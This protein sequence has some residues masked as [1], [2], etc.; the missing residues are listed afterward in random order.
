M[1][2]QLGRYQRESTLLRTAAVLN[3]ADTR[4]DLVVTAA[5]AQPS[6]K[7]SLLPSILDRLIEPK[8]NE[9]VDLTLRGQSVRELEEAVR[10]DLQDLLNTRQ[11][12]VEGYP[13]DTEL[14]HSLLT[15]GLPELSSFDPTIPDQRRS[16]QAI[17]ER[18][19]R[20]FE[21]RLMDVRVTSM[22]ADAASGR[23]LR[24]CVEALLRVSPAPLPITFDTV[25]KPGSGEWQVVEQ[26]GR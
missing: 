2:L 15:F 4:I 18:T 17:I 1:R 13:D 25:V 3:S 21:P 14:S 11:T 5:M 26:G 20:Q 10:R 6:A 12:A 16:L 24:M 8:E 19:I 9:A 22:T 23:G 7:S